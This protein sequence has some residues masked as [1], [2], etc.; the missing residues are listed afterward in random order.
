MR[1][2]T[3]GRVTEA[4]LRRRERCELESRDGGWA[5]QHSKFKTH[6]STAPVSTV[7]K[8]KPA[9]SNIFTPAL[10]G[11]AGIQIAHGPIIVT[12]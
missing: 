9:P 8:M 12:G 2:T 4:A 10:G 1:I 11:P 6:S 5:K 7:G 3:S